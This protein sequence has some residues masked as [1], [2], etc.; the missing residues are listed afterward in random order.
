M[1][2][3]PAVTEICEGVYLIDEFGGT[4]CY[5]VTGT[6]KALLIDCGTGF[7][8]MTAAI[9]QVTDKPVTLVATHGHCDHIGGCG[10]YEEMYI[11]KADTAFINRLQLTRFARVV[12]TYGNEPVRKNGFTAKDVTKNKH[13]TSLIPVSEGQRFDLGG[14]TVSVHFTPGHSRG[15]IALIDETDKIIFSGDNVCDALWLHLPGRLSVEEWID[16]ARWLSEMSEEYR[17]FWG[18]RNAELSHGYISQVV[19]WGEEILSNSKKNTLLPKRRRH[20]DTDEGIVYRTNT[21]FR[22]ERQIWKK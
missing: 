14:K 18:H 7:C 6:Q 12:F 3:V 8:D 13:K 1:N 22:K 2:K 19:K 15:S 10:Q 17:V 16:S 4:N 9:R 20:P 11:H 21:V 5:L